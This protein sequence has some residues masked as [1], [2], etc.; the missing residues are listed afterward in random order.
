MPLRLIRPASRRL[1]CALRSI[2]IV[3]VMMLGGCL[4]G[5]QRDLTEL[6]QGEIWLA[7]PMGSWLGTQN[8]GEPEAIA[9]CLVP[10]CTNRIAVGV[11]RLENNKARQT[12]AELRDPQL[13]VRRLN[14]R[15][16]SDSEASRQKFDLDATA[17]SAG[18]FDGFSLV[19]AK[20]G[21]GEVVLHA[22]AVG[23][24][25][26]KDLRVVFAVGDDAGVVRAAVAQLVEEGF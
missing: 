20:R 26:G 23:R 13:L 22:A 14:A 10:T 9:A 19:I 25:D 2:V 17:F 15:Q 5:Q 12:E 8:M 7:L 11:F 4:Y 21:D 1:P 16:E 24:R 3:T 6:A 18:G